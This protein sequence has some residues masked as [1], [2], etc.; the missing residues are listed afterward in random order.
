MILLYVGDIM[1]RAGREVVTRELGGLVAE[2]GVDFVLAQG[3]NLSGGKGMKPADMRAM[4][5]AGVGF[6]TGGNWTGKN[7]D[8]YPLLDDPSEPVI[9]PANYPLGTPGRGVKLVDTPFGII[10]V[11][12][13][14]GQTV[15]YIVPELDNPL[16][17]IDHILEEHKATRRVATVVNYHGDYSSEKLVI[18]QYLDGRVTA[19]VGDHWHT[20]TAD[21]EVLPGGTAHISDVGMVGSLDSC[22]GVKTSVIVQRWQTGS[23]SRNELET[24]GRMQ[25]NAVLIDVDT[26]T[27]L[28]RSIQHIR[29]IFPS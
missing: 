22:L 24:N 2:Y 8:I 19:V 11:V 29:R 21:A 25:L 6:F 14:L 5:Q 27:G 23:S 15:G 16:T 3:E 17:T 7:P 26:T 13:L 4:Q 18:G 12:S 28:S 9:R 10:L 1:G 20:P